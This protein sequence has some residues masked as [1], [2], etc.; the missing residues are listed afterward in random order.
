MPK[1]SRKGEPLSK[2]GAKLI[3]PFDHEEAAEAT[4]K[5]LKD[6]TSDPLERDARLFCLLHH[7]RYR[8]HIEDPVAGLWQVQHYPQDMD[9]ACTSTQPRHDNIPQW[10]QNL[11]EAMHLAHQVSEA[12]EGAISINVSRNQLSVRLPGQGIQ[13]YK[14]TVTNDAVEKAALGVC[15]MIALVCQHTAVRFKL[16]VL[17]ASKRAR[18]PVIDDQE[19]EAIV[20]ERSKVKTSKRK[21]GGT[22]HGKRVPIKL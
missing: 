1:L 12:F 20:G 6:P 3:P 21:P 16:P 17:G 4:I 15:L 13:V 14:I 18:I 9:T 8:G 10:S 5:C 7:T 11:N 2:R 22:R 19:L